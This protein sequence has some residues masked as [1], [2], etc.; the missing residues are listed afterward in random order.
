MHRSAEEIHNQPSSC[1][2]PNDP[3]SLTTKQRMAVSFQKEKPANRT[4]QELNSFGSG[5]SS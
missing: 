5:S 4:V 1:Q 3:D 2:P